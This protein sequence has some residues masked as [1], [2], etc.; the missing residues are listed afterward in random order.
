MAPQVMVASKTAAPS[1]DD[2]AGFSKQ[3]YDSKTSQ[4]SLDGAYALTDA[5]LNSVGFRGLAGYGVLSEIMKAATDKKSPAKREGAM[6]ALGAIWEKF[7]PKQRLSEVVFLVQERGL[8]AC[9]LDA[10][11]DK[12]SAVREGA[13]YALDQLFGHL[14][15][16]AKVF[17]L[18][19]CLMQYL[20][21]ATGKWQGTVGA[22]ELV[23]RMADKA[24]I[25]MES[26]EMEKDKDVLR[27][28]KG[29]CRIHNP[30]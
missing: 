18:L 27:E 23:G 15:S 4:Q 3:I 26:R 9:A 29:H 25:G 14:S 1:L 22:L 12:Q 10:L 28:A 30:V 24:K 19:P 7:P 17:G 11:A 13:R 8:V 6:F 16:E 20:G 2:M 21:T 5:L